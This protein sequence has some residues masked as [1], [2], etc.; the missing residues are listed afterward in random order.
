MEKKR[1]MIVDDE[2]SF[3]RMVKLC[4]E[5]TGNY[6]V[7]EENNGARTVE[8][9]RAFRPDL[10]L[11]DVIMPG[12]DGGDVVA[13][14]RDDG[15]LGRVPVIFLTATM[16]ED[17]MKARSGAIAG[18]PVVVKPVEAKKLIKEI[19]TTLSKVR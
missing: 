6:D 12:C 18:F 16:T 19:E 11:L 13:Q 4:L 15:A 8:T 1:I 7:L 10:I 3:T 14:L 9:A 17:G 5:Q 2:P